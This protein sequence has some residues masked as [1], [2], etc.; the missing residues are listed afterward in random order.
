M[1]QAN[2]GEIIVVDVGFSSDIDELTGPG[3][4]LLFP[5]FDSKKHKGQNGKVAVIGGGEYSG[6]P[7]LA[8]IGAYRSGV[9][10]VHVFVPEVSYEQVS[11]FAP[12]L[13]VHKLEGN[14]IT[15]SV[16]DSIERVR[17]NGHPVERLPNNVNISIEGV[18]GETVLLG[19]DLAGISAS[20]G[21]A[22]TSGSIE[23]SHVL[24]G[25]G[26]SSDVAQGSLRITIGKYTK[27]GDVE[28]IL[29]I[30]PELVERLR[31]LPTMSST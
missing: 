13:I 12:E 10:L 19:L 8:A 25:L 29:K 30:L 7:A 15:K 9:D 3:E 20:S 2:C 24:L 1:T 16:L 27:V 17:L 5:K 26:L 6:A 18:E 14:I 22:C 4:L 28:Y 23:P 11:S 31:S 21:S